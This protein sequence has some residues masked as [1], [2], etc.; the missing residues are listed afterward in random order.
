MPTK[1]IIFLIVVFVV[2]LA[3]V[4]RMIFKNRLRDSYAV[5]WISVILFIPISIVLYPLIAKL[6]GLTGF[7]APANFSFV[8]GFIALFIICLHFSEQNSSFHRNL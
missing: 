5:L 1:Q 7:V 3:W 4:L 2:L 8:L 6:G